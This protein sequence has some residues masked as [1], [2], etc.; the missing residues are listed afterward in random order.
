MPETVFERRARLGDSVIWPLLRGYYD[1]RGRRAWTDVPNAVTTHTALAQAFARLAA[2]WQRDLR[3]HARSEGQR[4]LYVVELG[5]GS[6]RFAH[7]FMQH[8]TRSGGPLRYVMT[9]F[10]ESNLGAAAAH[11]QLA[12]W[13]EAGV[14]DLAH[15]DLTRPEIPNLRRAGRALDQA[16]GGGALVV[17]ATYVFDSVPHD[18]F[19]VKDG[20]VEEGLVSHLTSAEVPSSPLSLASDMLSVRM[21][22]DYEKVVRPRYD[23]PSLDALLDLQATR[24][25]TT[26]LMPAVPIRALETL[27]AAC[28]GRM[29]LLAADKAWVNVTDDMRPCFALHSSLSSMTNFAAIRDWA[30]SIGGEGLLGPERA[31]ALAFGAFRFDDG[32]AGELERT[33][34]QVI[35]DASPDDR[36]LITGSPIREGAKLQ[37]YW[38]A[39]RLNGCD[40]RAVARYA[41]I[42]RSFAFNAHARDKQDLL[43]IVK[44]A[45]A[46]FFVQAESE[47]FIS[48]AVRLLIAFGL[49]DAIEPVFASLRRIYAGVID[50]EAVIARADADERALET[51]DRALKTAHVALAREVSAL[52][53]AER[54]LAGLQLAKVSD[55]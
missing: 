3:Q 7:G 49:R 10:A 41:P 22:I 20:V 18:F 25:G 40:P 35:V 13:A 32:S 52:Q 39:L 29:L 28:G 24:N 38:A 8:F 45:A 21:E 17:I 33:F 54:L 14:L 37:W 27:R 50:F 2:A 30:R 9:D 48:A 42:L 51:S 16:L 43:D 31:S 23:L 6:G 1:M 15:F 19:R 55:T 36:M 44:R 12:A 46:V 5:A 11:P 47:S 26:L 53:E 34:E 4:P